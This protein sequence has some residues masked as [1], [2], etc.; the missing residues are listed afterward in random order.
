MPFKTKK[1]SLLLAILSASNLNVLSFSLLLTTCLLR[2]HAITSAW[3]CLV[4]S[5]HIAYFGDKRFLDVLLVEECSKA[6]SVIPRKQLK[7]RSLP[8]IRTK[9]L[10]FLYYLS[11]LLYPWKTVKDSS[12]P[13]LWQVALW[14][15]TSIRVA[16]TTF[17]RHLDCLVRIFSLLMISTWIKLHVDTLTNNFFFFFIP[18]L[19]T[20]F[21]DRGSSCACITKVRNWS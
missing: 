8:S 4:T 7:L 2:A 18:C 19:H 16:D 13:T 14:L 5:V 6:S 12:H 11:A 3:W 17:R 9:T 21:I 15:K 10:A 1:C 20:W